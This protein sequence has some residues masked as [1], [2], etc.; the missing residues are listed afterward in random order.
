VSHQGFWLNLRGPK[1]GIQGAKVCF[2]GSRMRLLIFVLKVYASKGS[3]QS[4]E[5]KFQLAN[6]RLPVAYFSFVLLF[7]H[8]DPDPKHWLITLCFTLSP[9]SGHKISME[10]CIAFFPG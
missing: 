9:E 6:P 5:E 10:F 1:I 7:E 2:L 8:N 4:Y 3:F